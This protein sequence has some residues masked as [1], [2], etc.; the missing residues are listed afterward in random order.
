MYT[1]LPTLNPSLAGYVL[2]QNDSV[3]SMLARIFGLL[4]PLPNSVL[5]AGKDS[6]KY[7]TSSAAVYEKTGES[8]VSLLYA[9]KT[10][11]ATRLHLDSKNLSEDEAQFVDLV[12]TL[13]ELDP[14]KRVTATEALKHPW[15]A[16][17]DKLVIPPPDFT[18]PVK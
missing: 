13:L 5:L 12:K 2:F 17:V 15:L 6:Y 14:T 1:H 7:F 9:K 3:P 4:G 8:Q 11:L 10:N 18:K 16:D